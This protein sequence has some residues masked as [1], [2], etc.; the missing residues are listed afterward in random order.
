[1][2]S[3]RSVSLGIALLLSSSLSFPVQTSCTQPSLQGSFLQPY[4]GD[5]WTPEQWRKEQNSV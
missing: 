2:F 1:M 3:I 5:S 4:L